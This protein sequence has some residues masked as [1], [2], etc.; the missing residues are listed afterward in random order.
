MDQANPYIPTYTCD[1]I[2]IKHRMGSYTI[3]GLGNSN[4]IPKAN[5]WRKDCPSYAYYKGS[6]AIC[7]AVDT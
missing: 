4:T 2:N 3:F 6:L 1:A 5:Y 7:L